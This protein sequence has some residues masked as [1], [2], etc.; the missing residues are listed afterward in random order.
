MNADASATP[1]IV[2]VDGSSY[3]YRA[4]HALPE[5]HNSAGELVHAIRG[6]LSML[7]TL[8]N[9]YADSPI[10]VVL[11]APGKTFREDIYPPYKAHREKM[12]DELR[13]QIEP[14]KEG[15]LASGMPLLCVSDVEADDVIGTLAA[16]AGA[17]QPVLISASDKDL[18][19]LVNEHVT[20]VDTMSKVKLDIA[21]V[22]EKFGVPPELFIDYLA[23]R[24]DA[25]DNIPGV[26]GVGEKTAK[27]LLNEIG[28]VDAL[29]ENLDQVPDLPLRGAAGVRK[30]L[31]QDEDNARLSYRLATIRTDVELDFDLNHLPQVP[32]DAEKLLR[33]YED[34]EFRAWIGKL[35]MELSQTSGDAA[36]SPAVSA[37]Q[38]RRAEFVVA[39][40]LKTL[41][42]WVARM[43][44]AE[45]FAIEL[46][47]EGED[48]MSA[49]I[50]GLALVAGDDCVYAPLVGAEK[51]LA[52]DKVFSA[53]RPLFESESIVALGSNMKMWRTLLRGVGVDIRG[54]ARD[55]RLES[56]VLDAGLGPHDLEALSKRHLDVEVPSLK[57]LAGAGVKRVAVDSLPTDALAAYA[58]A[59][60]RAVAQLDETLYQRLEAEAKL[61]GVFK[62]LE[63]P[64]SAVLSDMQRDGVRVD[65]KLL[66]QLSR[67]FGERLAEKQDSAW[68]AAGE[69]FDIN[70]PK[71]VREILYEKMGLP[72]LAKTA[73]REPST[74][75]GALLKLAHRHPLPRLILDYRAL[76]KLKSTYTDAL[77][78]RV[79]ADSGRVHSSWMQT[80]VLT[81]RLS[82]AAPNLQNIPIRTEEGR[83]I[84]RAFV[85]DPGCVLL[86]MDY[87]QMEL[88]VMA[89]VS[90]DPGLLD[91]FGRGDDIHA[92]T[93]KEIFG[94]PGSKKEAASN[95][96]AAKAINFGLIYGMSAHGLAEQLGIDRNEAQN[97]MNMYFKRYTKVRDY[98]DELRRRVAED[99][100]VETYLGRRIHIINIRAK[101]HAH[102]AR[103]E[104]VAINAP[105]QG[106]AADIVKKAMLDV[107]DWLRDSG[108]QAR[109]IMQV[110]DELVLEAAEDECE[111]V[112]RQVRGL[113]ENA[114][115]LK[116][117]LVVD[118]GRGGNWDDAH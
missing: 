61:L 49:T 98:M 4:F 19:Q 105:I 94:E 32:R 90:G 65:V 51:A 11:D 8:R 103:A 34:W 101:S 50:V 85:A 63:M 81:G 71:Q 100:Y 48:F 115:E 12:P 20:L 113:M 26:A 111:E 55:V 89:H 60:A 82:S 25:S 110:H 102:R 13:S 107:S 91:A 99:G 116:A 5:M 24:G 104:R 59:R 42:E 35:K 18:A 93:A 66:G 1:P 10:V 62:D 44:A 96:D 84:R 92:A 106:T 114:V 117:P 23:L 108:A 56:Y 83:R 3:L 75:E 58:V 112:E 30:K 39:A 40:D 46:I 53:L 72:I 109:L 76:S 14:L 28:G 31:E 33:L 2:L 47:V 87:S 6:V 15:I 29:Y 41:T 22:K 45:R 52:S 16:Q 79:N 57:E 80:T 7:Q 73:K 97:Y 68:Q 88:R 70:S 17:R 27:V 86:A 37:T 36:A 95:R 54:A 77:P 78:E 74:A 43:E 21:G 69:E 118:V 9:T 38:D 64:L 67:E